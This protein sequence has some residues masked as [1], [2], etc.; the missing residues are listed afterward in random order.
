[1][2]TGLMPRPIFLHAIL[3][4]S[5]LTSG[6]DLKFSIHQ[7]FLYPHHPSLR[8]FRPLGHSPLSP[9]PSPLSSGAFPSRRRPR[10]RRPAPMGAITSAELNFLIFRYLQE[11][12]S[13]TLEFFSLVLLFVVT[14]RGFSCGLEI[15]LCRSSG[16]VL[17]W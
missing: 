4:V 1:M 7:F 6:D 12:G 2:P 9:L 16:S 15:Y 5:R 17:L 11:S 10:V 13:S 8:R 14:L 3:T